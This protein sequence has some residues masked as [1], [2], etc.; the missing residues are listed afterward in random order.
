MIRPAKINNSGR[1]ELGFTLVSPFERERMS[2]ASKPELS[3]MVAKQKRPVLPQKPDTTMTKSPHHHCTPTCKKSAIT[4]TTRNPPFF[5][6]AKAEEE[7][8]EEEQEA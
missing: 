3:R 1:P 7:E 6:E 4:G 8:E 2:I 5:V